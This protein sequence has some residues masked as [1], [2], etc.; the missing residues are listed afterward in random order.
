MPHCDASDFYKSTGHNINIL[1]KQPGTFALEN[2][3]L[4]KALH[5]LSYKNGLLTAQRNKCSSVSVW[6]TNQLNTSVASQFHFLNYFYQLPL[7][8]LCTSPYTFS[9]SKRKEIISQHWILFCPSKPH[10]SSFPF[11]LAVSHLR[12]SLQQKHSEGT[13]NCYWAPRESSHSLLQ[14]CG[15]GFPLCSLTPLWKVT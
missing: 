7:H 2:F 5:E 3:S 13:R 4:F 9:F 14:G 11:F 8:S 10:I 15:K 6:T 12:T 1:R